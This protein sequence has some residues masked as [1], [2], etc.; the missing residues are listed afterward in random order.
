MI[1]VFLF[2]GNYHVAAHR[3]SDIGAFLIFGLRVQAERLSPQSS[4]LVVKAR[5]EQ[6]YM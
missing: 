4:Y 3:K 5:G 2:S 1:P 6:E